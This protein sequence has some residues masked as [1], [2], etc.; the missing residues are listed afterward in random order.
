MLEKSKVE[1]LEN[2]GY[3]IIGEHRHSAVKVCHWTKKSLLDQ[4]VCYKEKFYGAELGVRSHL[5]LQL[6]PSIP[7]CDHRCIYCWRD[8]EITIPEWRGEVDEPAAILD[9]AIS[10]QRLLL[11]G[12]GGNPKVNRKKFMEAQ[13]PRHCAISLAGEPTIYPKLSGL[14]EECKKR[15]M[16]SFLVSNGLHP[17]ALE[18]LRPPTQLYIS[19]IAPD[20]ETYRDVCRPVA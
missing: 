11:S 17:E 12:F 2:A 20:G 15:G 3:R 8:T 6:T 1:A 14:I 10:A 7:F 13:K 9:H 16:S 18:R 19:L 5:C 4:G